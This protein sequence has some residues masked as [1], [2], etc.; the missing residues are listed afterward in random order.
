MEEENDFEYKS[1]TNAA[2]MCGHDGHI[3][4]LVASAQ[5]WAKNRNKMPKNKCIRLLF[6]PCEELPPGGAKPMIEEGCLEGV[7]EVYG[8]HNGPFAHEGS[9]SIRPGPLMTGVS[10]VTIIIEGQGGHG[11]EPAKS[12]DPI[13]AAC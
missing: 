13:T 2:Y 6:Q 3:A 5:F 4:T 11:S 10:K 1:L 8:Y 7:D 12:I 9:I